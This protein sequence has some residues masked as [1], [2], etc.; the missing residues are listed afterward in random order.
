MGRG[1]QRACLSQRDRVPK[2]PA[3]APKQPAGAI[4]IETQ[5]VR[6]GA[7][8]LVPEQRRVYVVRGRDQADARARG[9]LAKQRLRARRAQPCAPPRK[10]LG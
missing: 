6:A 7:R 5:S 3:R 2:Q 4:G 10:P 9:Q 1:P 8:L